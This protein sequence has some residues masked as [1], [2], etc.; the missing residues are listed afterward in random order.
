MENLEVNLLNLE[1]RDS[2]YK[3][4]TKEQRKGI[5]EKLLQQMKENKLT[6]GA[7]T[8]FLL[9]FKIS[10]TVKHTLTDK[11]VMDRL[12]FCLSKINLAKNEDLLFDDLYDYV[13][14]DEKWFY[15]TKTMITK[16]VEFVTAVHCKNMIIDNVIPASKSKS[17]PE[18]KRKKIYVQRDN[19]KPHFSDNDADIV[20]LASP[21]TI[22]EFI[23]CVQ[24]AL[25]HLEANMLDN[26]F[27]VLQ[28]CIESI[29][30]TDEGNG[31]KIP[32]LSKEKLRREG[33]LLEKYVCSKEAYVKA[34]SN[35]E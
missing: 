6:Q 30:L 2:K 31:Y 22:D 7:S 21:H 12:E 1:K 24:D 15:E 9:P 34:K 26:V 11:N 25:H 23:N 20:A 10:S 33:R 18:Y 32:H 14:I 3:E 27:T 5:L 16:N 28:A 35:F 19:T 17:T 29:M 13:H 8:N 4:L